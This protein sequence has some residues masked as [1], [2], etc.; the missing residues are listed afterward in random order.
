MAERYRVERFL[1]SGAM[2]EVYA[3]EDLSLHEHVALKTIRP[4]VA[5]APESLAR[6][7]REL[8]M[9]RRVTHPHV[10][11]VFDIGE[12]SAPGDEAGTGVAFLTMELLEGETLHAYL[13][14]QGRLP[15]SEVLRL[16]EQ[17][18]SALDAAHGAQVIHRDFK[19]SNVMRVPSRS[20]L[21]DARAVVTDF[22]LALGEVLE[23]D[24][25]I[26]RDKQLLGSPGYMSPEQVEG[27]P[28]TPA[29]DLY[30]FGVVLFELLTGRLP[31]LASTAAATALLRLREPPPS[32]RDLVPELAPSW[33]RVILRCLARL[34]HQRFPTASEAV[35]LLQ[36]IEGPSASSSGFAAPRPKARAGSMPVAR[37][38]MAVLAPR[39]LSGRSEA[40]WLSTALAE[41][42]SA[43]L[44]ASGQVRLLSGESVT[45]MRKDLSLPEEEGFAEDTLYRIRAWSGADLVLTGNYLVV[46]QGDSAALRLGLLV[47]EVATAET[48]AH[49]TLTGTERE[50]LELV[51]RT[52]ASLREKLGL[53]APSAEQE[54]ERHG[55]LPSDPEAARLYAEGLAASRGHDAATAVE[56]LERMLERE[57]SYAPAW[58]VLAAAFQQLHLDSRAK[59]AARRA[60]ELSSGLSGEERLLVRA[61]HHEAQA[62]WT[63]AIGAWQSL[64]GRFP[65]NVEYGTALASAQVS[66]G[67]MREA[68]ETLAAL[69]RLPA[70]LR[71]DVRIDLAEVEALS[72][73]SNFVA[74]R[75]RAEEAVRQARQVG[76]SQLAAAALVLEAYAARNLGEPARAVELLKEAERLFLSGGDR[77]GAARALLVHAFALKDMGRLRSAEGILLSA[78]RVAR[79]LQGSSLVAQVLTSA[80][81][82]AC[83]LGELN[84]AL[85]RALEA[86]E[87][88]QRLEMPVGANHATLVLG[89]VQ[90]YRGELN[91]AQ[92]LLE[93]AGQVARE[94]FQDDY[95]EAWARY[96]LGLLLLE[97]GALGQARPQLE[98][99]LELRQARGIRAFVAESE[100]ALARL[101]LEENRMEESLALAEQAL[102]SHAAL[103]SRDK[104]G[105][106]H[107]VRARA[108]LARGEV[109][110]ARQALAQA[111]ECA[112]D[113]E[114]LLIRSAILLTGAW[115]A[116]RDGTLQECEAQARRLH[117]LVAQ[118]AQVGL[119]SV[120]LAARL[121]LAE[122]SRDSTECEAIE[123]EAARLGY[124]LLARSAAAA[125]RS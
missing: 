93:Q 98:R 34:P 58:S 59:E 99:A 71:E 77:G 91:E 96:E 65:D 5:G 100:L 97:R 113:C 46:G 84:E 116:K 44:A 105:L 114:D 125:A 101:A 88:Y 53:G 28:L 61:R 30:S 35:A 81:V 42:V 27:Q 24:A 108:L 2:G 85:R 22:G 117:G 32:P 38:A 37:R 41:M 50:L 118:A 45:R 39:N 103:R 13:A 23:E 120:W 52:G 67:R 72:A 82:M 51:A 66:A 15:P 74:S 78:L 43:E 80:G 64:L 3:V 89:M 10:C 92:R 63:Q 18:A 49:L 55:V 68:Q 17:M 121:A 73:S 60:F 69:R 123:R 109:P 90:G 106:A 95:I 115:V 75:R 29:S 57:P 122:L 47:Q 62:E 87:L 104:E 7:K 33:E 36:S 54:P 83:Q 31:F 112:E 110:R 107:A 119:R 25:C 4:E 1:A 56:K 8:R 21:G 6:F 14:R 40:A 48:V 12:H 20:P 16:A 9:A 11:R 111:K 102:S 124:L 79:Q 26:T 94:R 19:S 86:L 70:P 76:Q